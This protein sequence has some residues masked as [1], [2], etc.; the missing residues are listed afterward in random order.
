MSY[1]RNC[2]ITKY[3]NVLLEYLNEF[4]EHLLFELRLN[5]SG[6]RLPQNF[7][8]V[9]LTTKLPPSQLTAVLPIIRHYRQPFSLTPNEQI[10][11]AAKQLLN[12]RI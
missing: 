1:F 12:L 5:K 10:C 9:L 6:L 8:L 7:I 3:Q 4:D 2:S 11:E